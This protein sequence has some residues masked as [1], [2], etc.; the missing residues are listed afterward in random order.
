LSQRTAWQRESNRLSRL[1]ERARRSGRRL[2]DLT[3]SNPTR[4]GFDD[5]GALIARLADARGRRYQPAAL[6]LL[7]AR[8]AVAAY[9]ARRGCAIAPG[10][11][12]LSSSSSESYSWLFKLL[13]DPG[14]VVLVPAPSYPLFPYLA[15][16]ESVRT[17]SYPLL[18]AERWRVDVGAVERLLAAEPRA[19]ALVAVH[20]GNPTGSWLHRDDA[21]ALFALARARSLSLVIDEVFLDYPH[22]LAA[23]AA[24]GSFAG[25]GD[26]AL[27]FVLSGL[28]KVALLPQVKLGWM[29]LSGADALVDEALG[30]LEVVADSYLSVSAAVQ[31]AAPAFLEAAER[32]QPRVQDR[33]RENL[34][35]VDRRIAAQGPGCPL[36]RRPTDGGWSALIEVPRTRSD[37]QWASALIEQ[38]GVLVYPGYFFD[39]AEPGTMVVSLL[40]EPTIF[41]E[42]IERAVTLWMGES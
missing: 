37:E 12:V 3:E 4:C 8:A 14:D 1:A 10:R 38:A 42:A 16:L 28:S 26:E 18:A 27:C 25:S 30:R 41:A 29:V 39:I 7:E 40:V 23:R 5:S 21:D 6:G 9:Y 17:R 20:P 33:L 13:C 15:E 31:L 2:L 22:P 11:V 19:R 36:R 24:V 35:A 32:L 34:A